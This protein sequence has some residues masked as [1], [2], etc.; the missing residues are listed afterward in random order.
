M[1]YLA[2]GTISTA[3]D[4]LHG[5]TSNLAKGVSIVAVWSFVTAI[6]FNFRDMTQVLFASTSDELAKEVMIF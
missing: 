4:M 6:H 2:M 5:W 1:T 3:H